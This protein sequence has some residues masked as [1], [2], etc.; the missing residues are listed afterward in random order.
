MKTTSWQY[1]IGSLEDM[2]FIEDKGKKSVN[3]RLR[4]ERKDQVDNQGIPVSVTSQKSYEK[5]H[6]NCPTEVTEPLSTLKEVVKYKKYS[7]SQSGFRLRLEQLS[8]NYIKRWPSSVKTRCDNCHHN[9]LMSTKLL[10][11][12]NNLFRKQIHTSKRHRM[13]KRKQV[14]Y[15]Q[16]SSIPTI[17]TRS[18]NISTP[19]VDTHTHL[20]STF[21][22]FRQSYPQSA[23]DDIFSFVRWVYKPSHET[24]RVDAIVDVWCDAPVIPLWKELADSAIDENDRIKQWGGVNYWFVM[25]ELI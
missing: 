24:P 22:K 23:I 12:V 20:L 10:P 1:H 2:L 18:S 13:P 14:T 3:Q 11:R 7:L 16:E 6:V 9:C 4:V 19:I 15:V 17:Y 21:E 5:S 8:R 25:G